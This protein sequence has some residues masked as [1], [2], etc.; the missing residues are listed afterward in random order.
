MTAA[1][2]SEQQ[3]TDLP[4]LWAEGLFASVIGKRLG[5]STNAVIGKAHRMDLPRRASPLPLGSPTRASDVAAAK[6]VPIKRAPK[7]TPSIPGHATRTHTAQADRREGRHAGT[8][9]Q[10]PHANAPALPRQLLL[11][12]G[13]QQAVALLRCAS[14]GRQAVLRGPR[15]GCVCAKAGCGG[16]TPVAYQ[17]YLRRW[18]FAIRGNCPRRIAMN[19]AE[20][21]KLR[22]KRARR[23]FAMVEAGDTLRQ[24]AEQ[25]GISRQRVQ[26]LVSELP[27]Y[28]I[29]PRFIPQCQTRRHLSRLLFR[30]AVAA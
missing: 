22:L 2:W 10:A 24:I 29:T 17:L 30:C 26:Q 1:T 16:V 9:T 28:R 8:T 15:Q 18:Q 14:S 12:A 4:R 21:R 19:H 3:L 23:F 11:G 13:R 20:M 5:K 6:V 7:I 25:E 27:E